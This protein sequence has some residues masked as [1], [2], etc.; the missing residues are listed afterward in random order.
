M[1]QKTIRRKSTKFIDHSSR[2]GN[3]DIVVADSG[4]MYTILNDSYLVLELHHGVKSSEYRSNSS[5][6]NDEFVRSYF[7]Y[8]KVYFDLRVIGGEPFYVRCSL[9]LQS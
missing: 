3:T 7:D 9:C 1:E 6:Y 2:N 8:S 5:E 4:K